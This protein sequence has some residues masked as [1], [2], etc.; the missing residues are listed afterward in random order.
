ME[1]GHTRFWDDF[2]FS[3][4]A[5]FRRAGFTIKSIK[6]IGS[7]TGLTKG[8]STIKRTTLNTEIRSDLEEHVPRKINIAYPVKLTIENQPHNNSQS[9]CTEVTPC[10]MFTG[11]RKTSTS[12]EIWVNHHHILQKAG[13]KPHN[14]ILELK[15]GTT[16][17]I[18]REIKR[19]MKRIT[20][21]C[22]QYHKPKGWGKAKF[23]KRVDW[24]NGKHKRLT[25]INLTLKKDNKM[26]QLWVES[27]VNE[28]LSR[29]QS[30]QL[31]RVGYFII[32]YTTRENMY[33]KMNF[34]TR[35]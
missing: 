21:R 22:I 25:T 30:F 5:S 10:I 7:Q 8:V 2:R 26:K 32:D 24:L 31:E 16:I 9:I 33:I 23:L 14:H 28:W 6:T 19:H 34:T 27:T 15:G 12:H 3:S 13:L 29:G 17:K 4:I 20:I 11:R 18:L 1:K 35:I